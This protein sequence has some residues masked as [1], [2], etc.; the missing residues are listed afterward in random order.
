M[1]HSFSLKLFILSWISCWILS[2]N[3]AVP[4]ECGSYFTSIHTITP[5]FIR[6][7]HRKTVLQIFCMPIIF[8]DREEFFH[9]TVPLFRFC[10]AFWQLCH[11]GVFWVT[12]NFYKANKWLNCMVHQAS[13]DGHI[14]MSAISLAMKWLAVI[15]NKYIAVMHRL[16]ITLSGQF[17]ETSDS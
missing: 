11:R 13:S 3:S 16:S 4:P 12:I 6:T 15:R 5:S 8:K 7:T 2:N 1:F 14:P 9:L 10:S 17:L